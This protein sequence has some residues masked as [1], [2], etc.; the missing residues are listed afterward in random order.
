MVLDAAVSRTGAQV[1]SFRHRLLSPRRIEREP[2][3]PIYSD[4]SAFIGSTLVALR[5]GAKD[6]AMA[7][8]ASKAATENKVIGSVG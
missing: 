4:R 7:T 1:P 8:A 5:A 2:Q 6:A 3:Y